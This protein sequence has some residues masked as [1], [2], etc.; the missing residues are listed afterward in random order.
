MLTIDIL[1]CSFAALHQ[2]GMESKQF[3]ILLPRNSDTYKVLQPINGL[4]NLKT[5]SY[6]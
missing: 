3:N 5:Q 6:N 1:N 4:N 2:N